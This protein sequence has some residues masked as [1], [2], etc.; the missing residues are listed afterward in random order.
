MAQ[1]GRSGARRIGRMLSRAGRG[2]VVA[3]ALSSIVALAGMGLASTRE[4]STFEVDRAATST[5]GDEANATSATSPAPAAIVVH[6]DGAVAHP[7]VYSLTGSVVRVADA[8]SAAGGLSEDAVT[9]GVNLAAP[10]VD[11]SKVHIP[12]AG[13]GGQ[14]PATSDAGAGTPASDASSASGLVNIN[15]ADASAL[16]TLPGVGAST[17]AAI[18]EDREQNGPFTSVD[19]LMRV[20][21]IGEKKFAKIK[22]HICV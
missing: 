15:S 10:V 9:D 1:H 8:V 14:T 12:H 17:A 7:G 4:A 6:V 20:S 16:D 19:D 3:V 11:G 21:G 2:K 13:D 5:S 22:G 18:I